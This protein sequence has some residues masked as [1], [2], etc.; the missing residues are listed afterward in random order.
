MSDGRTNSVN[1]S[2]GVTPIQ[3]PFGLD[4]VLASSIDADNDG[5][6]RGLEEGYYALESLLTHKDSYGSFARFG[7]FEEFAENL[8]S[9]LNG[10][11]VSRQE[12]TIDGDALQVESEKILNNFQLFS[13]REAIRA[14]PKNL[15]KKMFEEKPGEQPLSVFVG[16]SDEVQERLVNSRLSAA[17][18][19][20]VM[21]GLESAELLFVDKMKTDQK[22]VPHVCGA[23]QPTLNL[24][25]YDEKS[26][27]ESDMEDLFNML[28]HE[29]AHYLDD[30]VYVK[31]KKGDDINRASDL[32]AMDQLCIGAR[33]GHPVCNAARI[34]DDNFL[35]A[36]VFAQS[37]S[38]YLTERA[39]RTEEEMEIISTDPEFRPFFTAAELFLDRYL[40]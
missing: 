38:Y 33:E 19:S 7:E 11:D 8:L 4:P 35:T 3:I 16:D 39:Y 32:D 21:E 2:W 25:W 36:D 12:V 34:D 18:I 14:Y 17:T 40:N 30:T 10:A 13:I 22:E 20:M 31:D 24:V 37:V 6:I 23:H 15:A 29:M 26:F 5:F 28:T 27:A 9:A 1:G